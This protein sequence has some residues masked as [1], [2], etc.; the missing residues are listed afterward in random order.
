[1][2]PNLNLQNEAIEF[3]DFIIEQV[4]KTELFNSLEKGKNNGI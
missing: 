2:V 1:M 4:S 3:L